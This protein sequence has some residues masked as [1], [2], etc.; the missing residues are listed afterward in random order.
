MQI[1]KA[2]KTCILVLLNYFIYLISEA[3]AID[4]FAEEDVLSG[5]TH[6]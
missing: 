3:A 2:N 4:F 1:I 5:T 6:F